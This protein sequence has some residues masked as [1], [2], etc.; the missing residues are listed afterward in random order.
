MFKHEIK[1]RKCCCLSKPMP[2]K[3]S[4][5]CAPSENTSL[6]VEVTWEGA[7]VELLLVLVLVW[8]CPKK[9]SGIMTPQNR[10]VESY[11]EGSI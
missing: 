8:G 6:G 3:N 1:Q 4:G 9:T 11:V 7:M 10:T 2:E 5:H